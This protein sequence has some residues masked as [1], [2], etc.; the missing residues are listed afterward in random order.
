MNF[1]PFDPVFL[2]LGPLQFHY[3]GL[4][5]VLAFSFAYFLLPYIF[6]IRKVDVNK[7]Q[8]ENLFFY[9]ALGAILGGRIFYVLFYNFSYYLQN[10][11]KIFA[12]WEGGMASHG[13]FLGALITLWILCKIYNLKFLKISDCFA[14]PSGMGLMFGRIGNLINGELYGRITDVSWCMEFDTAEGCR[15]PSQIYAAIKNFTLFSILFS[16]RKTQWKDG[17]LTFLFISLYAL[18]R[19][20][21]EFFREPDAHIGLLSLGLSQGQWISLFFF[22]AGTG[23]III[24]QKTRR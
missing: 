24:N 2:T 22:I 23:A 19:F 16:L 11:L 14:I 15:H 18:F 8:F 7:N 3:Y 6:G 12:V 10:P 4:M 17:T 13:G 1:T 5:Y 21:V 20:I 9:T